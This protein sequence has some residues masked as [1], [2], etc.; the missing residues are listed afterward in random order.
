M[1]EDIGESLRRCFS[2]LANHHTY[3]QNLL[4][5]GNFVPYSMKG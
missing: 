3:L 4:E 5:M 2:N 1:E